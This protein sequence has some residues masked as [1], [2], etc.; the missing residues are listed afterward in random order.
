MGGRRYLNDQLVSLAATWA[1]RK[2]KIIS[3]LRE[4]AVKVSRCI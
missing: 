3:Y 2:N 1:R 4:F